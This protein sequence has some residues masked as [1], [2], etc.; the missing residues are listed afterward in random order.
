MKYLNK[1]TILARYLPGL[2]TLIPASLIYFFLTKQ[3]SDYSL[4][5]YLT[6]ITFIVGLSGSFILTFFMSMI[7]RELGYY[8]EKKYF[9]NKLGFPST[10][11]MLFR[12]TK[13][14]K[15]MK[16]L[17]GRKIYSDFSLT[18]LNEL[19][20]V[21]DQP[22]A[23]RVLSQASRM[24]STRYQQNEQVKDAN[25]AYGFCRNVS[26]GLLISIPSAIAGVC[27]GMFIHL[28]PLVFWSAL[29]AGIYVLVAFF[30]KSWITNNSEKYAEKL[31]S[32]Y[33]G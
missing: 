10:Y 17:Y 30:H 32:V 23:L 11:L 7:V 4:S 21:N 2:I 33:L 26:G 13:F 14:P 25:I 6:S 1:Y 8:L 15:Q 29:C 24:L 9:K 31:F 16:N 18:R 3:E 27:V 28:L 20:E 19:E 22:E 5:E 12:D